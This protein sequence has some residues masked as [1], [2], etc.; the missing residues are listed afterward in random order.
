M[1]N[2]TLFGNE[3]ISVAEAQD[4]TIQSLSEYGR[5]HDH[6][7]IAWSGGKDSTCTM[8]LVL[9]LIKS[10]QI[11][12]PKKLTVLY[13][14]TRMEL[15][16][17]AISAQNMIEQIKQIKDFPCELHV[18][19]VMAPMDKRYFVYM[20]GRGVTP[21]NNNTLRWCTPSLKVKPMQDRVEEEY[22]RLNLP[23]L[24]DNFVKL[25]WFTALAGFDLWRPEK[26]D[27]KPLMITGVR[28]GESAIRDNRIAMSCTKN[29]AECG[30]GWYQHTIPGSITSTLAPIT[31]WRVCT[32]W[33]WL[34][35][36]A[37]MDEIGGW[38]T[39][40]LA[41]AYGADA[42]DE[43]KARTGCV[44]CPLANEDTALDKVMEL[45]PEKWGYL[46]PLKRLRPLYRELRKAKHRLRKHGERNKNGEYS[47]SP[48]R[49]GPLTMKAR[50]YG[51]SRILKIQQDINA[52]AVVEDRPEIDII[53]QKEVDR[54]MEL[55]E[56]NTWPQRWNGDE[57]IATEPYQEI[58]STGDIQ[59][60]IFLNA[61]NS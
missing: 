11:D 35:I 3:K 40:M 30:Q 49:M 26:L 34:K 7:V 31:H 12:P 25:L 42:D 47:S 27:Q 13:A 41:E 6:W 23:I 57:P 33:D 10:G 9:Y 61:V 58:T 39:E 22:H 2:P 24:I 44:G 59:G 1:P 56:A 32:V 38:D 46:K 54:I 29:G 17:L 28:L 45:Y 50:R 37:P 5:N 19:T 43:Y 16:P 60:N 51:L 36:Y 55:I 14:D 4:I 15:P 8:T 48:N 18:E 52:K 53:N 21:P 20:F